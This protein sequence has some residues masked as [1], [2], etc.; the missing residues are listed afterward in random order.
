[1]PA[2][3]KRPPAGQRPEVVPSVPCV[4]F[5]LGNEA[6][7]IPEGAS[8]PECMK[9]VDLSSTGWTL[10][11]AVLCPQSPDSRLNDFFSPDAEE[12]CPPSSGT[13]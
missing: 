1:M 10:R 5:L 13:A 3:A 4:K 7:Q 2:A 8:P 6:Y 9:Q 11:D 12:V